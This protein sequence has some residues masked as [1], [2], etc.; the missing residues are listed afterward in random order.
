[1]NQSAP[2]EIS[3]DLEIA[4]VENCNASPIPKPINDYSHLWI[5]PPAR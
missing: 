5:R 2:S 4:L 1:M 3:P